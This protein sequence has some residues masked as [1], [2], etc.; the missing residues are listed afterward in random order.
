MLQQ[1]PVVF[2]VG[3]DSRHGCGVGIVSRRLCGT[4]SKQLGPWGTTDALKRNFGGE[5]CHSHIFYVGK[6]DFYLCNS[7]Y[8]TWCNDIYLYIVFII[9]YI[10][11]YIDAYII[12]L[13]F[14]FQMGGTIT[15]DMIVG[16][17]CPFLPNEFSGELSSILHLSKNNDRFLTSSANPTVNGFRKWS[18]SPTPQGKVDIKKYRPHLDLELHFFF[19][20]GGEVRKPPFWQPAMYVYIYILYTLYW[21]S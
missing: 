16:L 7:I 12:W 6:D 21:R 19:L 1:T 8:Y 5:N 2:P 9:V 14:C 20:G 10:Y 13:P 3:I 11:I 15:I 4:F 17:L 18:N